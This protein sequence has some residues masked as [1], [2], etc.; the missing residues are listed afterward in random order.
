MTEEVAAR[1]ARAEAAAKEAAE[2]AKA[3]E[4]A[5]AKVAEEYAVKAA[6][7]KAATA[8][9]SQLPS[10]PNKASENARWPEHASEASGTTPA[11]ES[12]C[13]IA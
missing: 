12:W 2:A 13:T 3:A 4:R 10:T 6:R 8:T 7:A 1:K 9:R 5:A 11:A